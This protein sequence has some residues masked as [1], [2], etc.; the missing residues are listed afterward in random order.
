[1]SLLD[2]VN[3]LAKQHGLSIKRL[4]EECGLSNATIRRW[5]DQVPNVESV[6][7]VAHRLNVTIDYLVTGQSPNANSAR[8]EVCCDGVPLSEAEADLVAMFR[9]LPEDQR[10]ELFD[11][12]FFKY[13][14]FVELKKESIY[15][16]YIDTQTQQKNSDGDDGN[17]G[18]AAGGIA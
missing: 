11:L 4:E 18:S 6:Q 16:T 2:R 15:S 14:R 13:R 3:D 5:K 12:I 1:M 10:A 17:G 7:K 8:F 9:L